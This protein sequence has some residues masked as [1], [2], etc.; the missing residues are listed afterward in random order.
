MMTCGGPNAHWDLQARKINICYEL[1]ADFAGMYRDYA[2]EQK[3][4]KTAS[5]KY[6]R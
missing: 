6:K 5:R 3:P 1:A 4:Q 2:G